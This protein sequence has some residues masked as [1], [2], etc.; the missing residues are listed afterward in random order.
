MSAVARA[1]VVSEGWKVGAFGWGEV[2]RVGGVVVALGG[3]RFGGGS[4]LGPF[5]EG[6]VFPKGLKWR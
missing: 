4:F 6:M 1:L 3:G 2:C 5:L